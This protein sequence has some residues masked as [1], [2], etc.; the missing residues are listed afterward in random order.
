MR[1][2]SNLLL[3]LCALSAGAC[4]M[5]PLDAGGAKV[6]LIDKPWEGCDYVTTGYGASFF[7]EYAM[8]N[9]RNVMAEAGATHVVVTAETQVGG[10]VLPAGGNSLT[11]RGIGYKCP[12]KPATAPVHNG[13]KT[14]A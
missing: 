4:S 1:L 12:P 3:L 2:R 5:A 7:E 10:P 8:N 9:L 13:A 6:T 11:L 14:K